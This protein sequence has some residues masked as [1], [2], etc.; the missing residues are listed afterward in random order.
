MGFYV[1]FSIFN[2]DPVQL[3]LTVFFLFDLGLPAAFSFEDLTNRL[4]NLQEVTVAISWCDEGEADGHVMVTFE[5]WHIQDWDME[6]LHD[7]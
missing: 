1:L 5:A 3:I 4:A 2:L 6:A 7:R